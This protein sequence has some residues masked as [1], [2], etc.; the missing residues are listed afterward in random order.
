MSTA[1]TA[2]HEPSPGGDTRLDTE[3]RHIVYNDWIARWFIGASVVWGLVGMLVGAL[4]A[5][6]LAF[7]RTS[8]SAAS[9]R[10]TRT[11]SSSRSSAT[12]SLP[13]STTRRSA[14]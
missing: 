6:Q 9:G 13:A 2:E 8:P 3:T 4:A 5:L 14:S 11:P 12:W 10:S 1:I 7:R